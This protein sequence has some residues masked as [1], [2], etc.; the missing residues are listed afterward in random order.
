MRRDQFGWA[1]SGFRFVQRLCS[2][3]DV[4]GTV[5]GRRGVPSVFLVFKSLHTGPFV[6]SPKMGGRKHTM[7]TL[8]VVVLQIS[9]VSSLHWRFYVSDHFRLSLHTFE[10]RCLYS[11][12]LVKINLLCF[13]N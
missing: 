4:L 5:S 6:S 7:S 9:Q 10:N 11:L 13:S 3:V 2:E 1:L 8:C 12:F